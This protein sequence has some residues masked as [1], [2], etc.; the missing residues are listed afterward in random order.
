MKLS[1]LDYLLPEEFIAQ[2]PANPR[3]SSKLLVID[4]RKKILS[5]HTFYDLPNLLTNRDVLVFNNTKVIPARL[6][7]KKITG[8]RVELLLKKQINTDTWEAIFG[9]KLK[10]GSKLIFTDL[11]AI[12]L[13][14][15]NYETIIKFN[16]KG[17]KL[18]KHLQD[19]GKTPLPPYINSAESESKSRKD[20]QTVYAKN[21][22]S[23]AAPT[24]GFHFTKRL[25]KKIS[26]NGIQTEFLT[27]H[28]GLGTFAP[29]KEKEV[30]KHQIHSESFIL[31]VDVAQRLNTAKKEGRRIIAVGTTTTRVLENCSNKKGL[32]TGHQSPSTTCL[33]I[34]P[35]YKFKFVDALI[36]NFHLPKSS[37]L[38][39]VCA[40]ITHPNTDKK[41]SD[42]KHSLLG[43]AYQE[44]IK[45]SYRF[46]SFG[47]AMFIT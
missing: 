36:T 17:A 47:D 33:F 40:F 31:P 1:S 16:E 14:L 7:G 28:V 3:D 8:G 46:Y 10:I 42:F 27:L 37:L 25:L 13:D 22:G 5:H 29:I 35:P 26:S 41:F 34:Y 23:V 44:A 32:L 20:Y 18:K 12:V 38:A 30:E 15:G 43:K 39:L 2:S 19:L 11:E 4:R 21:I 24:A 45:R 6:I 9:G